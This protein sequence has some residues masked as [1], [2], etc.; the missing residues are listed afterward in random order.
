MIPID[1]PRSDVDYS[2]E[3]FSDNEPQSKQKKNSFIRKDSFPASTT[4]NE[5]KLT[6]KASDDIEHKQVSFDLAPSVDN[7]V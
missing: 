4:L 6:T 1:R 7:D 2:T 5:E 3:K